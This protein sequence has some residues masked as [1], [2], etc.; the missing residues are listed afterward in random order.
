MKK[1]TEI[2]KIIK[3]IL[4]VLVLIVLVIL[5]QAAKNSAVMNLKNKS[6]FVIFKDVLEFNYLENDGAAWGMLGGKLQLFTVFTI[7]LLILITAA[8]VYL[9][10][11]MVYVQSPKR[12]C[13]MQWILVI[14]SAG[15]IGNL[16]DRV[17]LNYVVDFIYFKLINF[18]VFNIADCFV[19]ISSILLAIL[20]LFGIK[21]SDWEIILH[22]NRESGGNK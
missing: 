10:R 3:Y 14:L 9:D 17:R 4:F 11:K 13:L 2:N 7:A 15:A 6:S 8:I 5:D 12:V 22:G 18:P 19:V 20:I 16:I 1:T 21:E